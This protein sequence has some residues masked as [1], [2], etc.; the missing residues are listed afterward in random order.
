MDL[1]EVDEELLYYAELHLMSYLTDHNKAVIKARGFRKR[2]WESRREVL[3]EGRLGIGAQIS[4][5]N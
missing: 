1:D 2:K 3:T 4:D 5:R